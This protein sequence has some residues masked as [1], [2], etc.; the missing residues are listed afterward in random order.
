MRF[1]NAGNEVA[2]SYKIWLNFD[3]AK[4]DWIE[5][6]GT[7]K[8][9]IPIQKNN[10]GKRFIELLLPPFAFSTLRFSDAVKE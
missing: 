2:K 10:Q 3:A 1:Y 4:V 6:N 9:T 8:Q 7:V 5:L